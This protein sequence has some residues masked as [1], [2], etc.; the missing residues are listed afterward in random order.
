MISLYE[1]TESKMGGAGGG[2]WGEWGVIAWW[3]QGFGLG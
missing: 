2:G 1:E 3:V